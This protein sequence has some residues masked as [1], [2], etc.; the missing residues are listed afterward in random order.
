[1][2]VAVEQVLNV[3]GCSLLA[4]LR[5]ASDLAAGGTRQVSPTPLPSG[6]V[7]HLRVHPRTVSG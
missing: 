3:V 1:M 2:A 7:H 5:N 4:T 6:V